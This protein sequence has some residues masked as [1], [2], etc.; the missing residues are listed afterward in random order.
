MSEPIDIPNANNNG[1]FFSTW[2]WMNKNKDDETIFEVQDLSPEETNDDS[3]LSE[4]EIDN[5][6]QISDESS[7]ENEEEVKSEYKYVN[8]KYDEYLGSKKCMAVSNGICHGLSKQVFNTTTDI[9]EFIQERPD[10]QKVWGVFIFTC[11]VPDMAPWIYSYLMLL[12]FIDKMEDK[13]HFAG[14]TYD[15]PIDLTQ[16]NDEDPG[17]VADNDDESSDP[18]D[19]SDDDDENKKD[20]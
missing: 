12:A 1:G 13:A 5:E 17:E 9:C 6:M 7:N 10:W 15:N 3:K 4:K 18:N 16:D 11:T 8:V 20:K 19:S 14:K 2:T